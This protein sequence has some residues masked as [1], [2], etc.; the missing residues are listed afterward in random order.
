ME[1]FFNLSGISDHKADDFIEDEDINMVDCNE[2]V[3]SKY[4]VQ[5]EEAVEEFQDILS[6]EEP[7]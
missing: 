2:E 6:R 5:E 7:S 1:D 4:F 3:D